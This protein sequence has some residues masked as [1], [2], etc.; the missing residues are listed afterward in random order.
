MRGKKL[1]NLLV[2]GGSTLGLEL[3]CGD[4]NDE[5]PPVPFVQADKGVGGTR[6]SGKPPWLDANHPMVVD[7]MTAGDFTVDAQVSTPPDMATADAG[8]PPSTELT[9]CGFCPNTLCC[10]TGQ[11]G[12]P[13]VKAGFECCWSTSC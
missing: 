5:T 13:A 7:G 3:A 4:L 2:I 11:D 8:T 9:D 1:F 6:D 12:K 10:E